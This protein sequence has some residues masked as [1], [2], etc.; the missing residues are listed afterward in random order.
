MTTELYNRDAETALLGAVLIDPS[1]LHVLTIKPDEFYIDIHKAIWRAFNETSKRGDIDIIT[2][3]DELSRRG[4]DVGSAYLT[5]LITTSP[6]SYNAE[7]YAAI[8]SDF[9]RRRADLQIA[10]LIAQGAHGEGVDR[11][12]VIDMLTTNA[13]VGDGA[14]PISGLL[15]GFYTGVEERSKAPADVWGVSTGLSSLDRATGG[16]HKQQTTMLAGSPGVGKTTLLLQIILH[17]AMHGHSCGVYELEMDADRLIGRI[18]SM[19]TSV[20]IRDMKT[21]R[22]DNHWEAFNQ[23]VEKLEHLKLYICDNPVMSTMQIRADVARLQNTRGVELV[24]LDYLNLLTDKESD[25][26]N[27]NVTAKAVRFRQLCREFEVSGI[28]VQSITKEGMRAIV[29]NLADM[30]GPAEVGFTADNVFFLVG[31]QADVTKFTLL[32]AKMRDSDSGRIP[33]QLLK[34]KGKI[35]FGEPEKRL[36]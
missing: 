14:V 7:Y 18:V 1:Q 23:G 34:P 21:G 20:P 15:S 5:S 31:D 2:V 13:G 26:S 30:S 3:S 25:N 8:V 36:Y 24:G 33:I 19:L 12:K 11:A 4:S 10:N 22:M 32:P 6:A 35:L 28:S 27:E 17:A 29:P 9:A 16:L